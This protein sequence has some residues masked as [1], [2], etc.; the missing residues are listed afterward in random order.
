[1]KMTFAEKV[2]KKLG[3]LSAALNSNNVLQIIRDA[4]LAYVPVTIITGLFLI[5]AFFPVQG[6]V[7]FFCGIFG[8]DNGTWISTLTMLY[9]VGLGIGGFLVLLTASIAAAKKLGINE[10]SIILTNVMSFLVLIPLKEGN[11]IATSDL[12]ANNMFMALVVALIGS[13]LFKYLTDKNIKIKM[14]DVVPP[15]V[16][17]PFE[18][19]IPAAVVMSMFWIIRLVLA[20]FG[21][22]FA[23]FIV[24]V[25]GTPMRFVGGNIFGVVFTNIFMQLLWFFGIHGSSITQAFT[26]PIYQVLS[27]EN[28]VAAMAGQPVPNIIS[29]E[30]SNYCAIG[31]VGAVIAALIVARSRRYREVA[32]ITAVPYIFGVGEPALFGF[33]L[34]MNFTFFIPFVF[35]NAISA[36]IAYIGMKTGL[37]AIPTG[38]MS[39]PWTTP[40]ILKGFLTNQSISGAILEIV[41]LAVATALWLPFIRIEDKR[42]CEQEAA[43]AKA[44]E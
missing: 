2:E 24:K 35:G 9:N 14:P 38:L 43:E 12:S 15:M 37:V 26:T 28:R 21:M 27:E 17:K 19:L 3:E 40:F 29:A 36:L 7:D 10:S 18:S 34:M 42:I 16:S 30:F 5:L 20:G 22:T 4:M 6:V 44:A 41:Q 8:I 32:K 25:L 13:Y 23:E 33:P 39:V 31:V 11:Q 1:M